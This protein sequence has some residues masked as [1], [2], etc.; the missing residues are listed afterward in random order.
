MSSIEEIRTAIERLP[1]REF[2][3]FRRWFLKYD[4]EV[5]D[6]QIE[7]DES[8]GNLDVFKR[9]ALREHRAGR[10]KIL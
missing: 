4:A 5:W 2:A 3:R 1:K 7:E 6:K 8:A 10:T 9:E